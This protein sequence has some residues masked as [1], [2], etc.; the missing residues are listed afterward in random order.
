MYYKLRFS[1]VHF[2]PKNLY[3]TYFSACQ[4]ALPPE[5]RVFD[6]K[7]MLVPV[8]NKVKR[9]LR[10]NEKAALC[11]LTKLIQE[12]KPCVFVAQRYL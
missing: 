11:L 4:R 2:L 8:E 1:L 6:L 9:L 3:L 12:T 5:F 7:D 10:E